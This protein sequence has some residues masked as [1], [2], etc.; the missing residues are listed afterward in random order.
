MD[1]LKNGN[2]R[3]AYVSGV[4]NRHVEMNLLAISPQYPLRGD[5]PNRTVI[6]FQ[7]TKGFLSQHGDGNLVK[8]IDDQ[9]A[10][11]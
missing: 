1:C 8:F 3:H 9:F 6:V 11:T 7:M 10:T 2:I 4:F 5:L